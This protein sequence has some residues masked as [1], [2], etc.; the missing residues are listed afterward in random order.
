ML[1][2]ITLLLCAVAS[3]SVKITSVHVVQSCHL[4]V[5]FANSAVGITN[6]YFDHHIPYAIEVAN[7]LKG[8]GY[9]LQFLAQVY[10]ISLYLN[11]PSG[12]GLHCP[13]SQQ[14]ETLKSAIRNGTIYYHAFPHNA[15][16]EMGTTDIIVEGIKQVHAMDDLFG[17]QR[18]KTLSQ[19]D[20]P[21]MTRSVIPT[22]L[23]EG[24]TTVSVGVNPASTYPRVPKVFRWFD[25]PSGKEIFA[26]WHPKGYGGFSFNESVTVPGLSHALVT[27]WNGDNAGPKSAEQYLE[28]RRQIQL[29]FPGAEVFS[30][31]FD[32]FTKHLNSVKDSIPIV[33]NEIGDSWIYG[34]PSDPKKVQLL[35]AMQRA[36]GQYIKSGGIRDSVYLNA[37]RL[38]LKG[39][40]HTWG[41]DVKSNLVD[42]VDWENSAFEA[43]RTTGVDHQQFQ[44]LEQSWW[45]Q[46][47]W[48]IN[49]PIEPLKRA[50]HS[51]YH[52]IQKQFDDLTPKIP[53]TSGMRRVHNMGEIFTFSDGQ[54]KIGFSSKTGAITTLTTKDGVLLASNNHP[55][56]LV[57]YTSYSQEDY[58]EFFKSYCSLPDPPG[59]F[60][61]DFGKPGDDYSKHKSWL[62]S[63][64][65]LFANT[66]NTSFVL[67]LKM[68][69]ND[70]HKEYG[71]PEYFY[72]SITITT[73]GLEA[74]L[75]AWNKT[76]TRLPESM[77][78]VFNPI[79]VR[80]FKMK[81]LTEWIA[82]DNTTIIDGG[83]T[84]LHGV[85]AA[86]IGMNSSKITI[87]SH[88]AKVLNLGIPS[89]FP[90]PE[91]SAADV[92]DFGISTVLW[93]N[94]WGTNYV[95]WYPFNKNGKPVVGEENLTFRFNLKW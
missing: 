10:Y 17:V 30:S 90:T 20:V 15:E 29:E 40:E 75:T 60:T 12:M 25:P 72:V 21:G 61:H 32:N 63:P 62:T 93:N 54:Q 86:Q 14:K 94:L 45:E 81:K 33:S 80:D 50:N 68:N 48:G 51:L 4:D 19:R 23:S 58:K 74:V 83:S 22:L 66:A 85:E 89:G 73:S 26:M 11:C 87:E 78:V 95:M 49:F 9:G 44:I 8:T 82:V 67:K 31:T 2:L 38:M 35:M 13:N 7:K 37:T 53:K 36:W 52:L 5:G 43:A 91:F 70:A 24:V 56:L 77:F 39:I 42:N 69:E 1:R 34:T 41:R 79:D 27:D 28:D 16:L 65:E 46:R 47:D 64:I 76:T 6:L 84:H 92:S 18:K 55:L 59:W 3:S 71:A 88:D 57:N